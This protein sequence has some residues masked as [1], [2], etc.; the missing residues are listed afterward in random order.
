MARDMADTYEQNGLVNFLED[1]L[2]AHKKHDWML[3]S[4]LK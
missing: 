2:D 4:T 3:R 1:R